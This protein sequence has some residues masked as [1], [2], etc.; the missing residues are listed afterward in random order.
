MTAVDP[1]Y[2][3]A[4]KNEALYVRVGTADP[5]WSD[6]QESKSISPLALRAD[7]IAEAQRQIAFVGGPVVREQAEVPGARCDLIGRPVVL[8]GP[9]LGYEEGLPVFVIGAA[10]GEA[11]TVLTVLRRLA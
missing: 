11:T 8:T 2:A 5:A 3:I 10:E 9:G 7:A 4:L 1:A 6:G